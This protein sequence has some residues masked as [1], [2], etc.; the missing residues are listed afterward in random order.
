M[1]FLTLV[2]HAKSSWEEPEC[3]D[4]DRPLN[5]RGC[6]DASKMAVAAAKMG[7]QPQHIVT[8]SSKRTLETLK[9]FIDA[10]AFK[11]A[12]VTSTESIYEASTGELLDIIA[13]QP[14]HFK[15]LAMVGHNPGLTDLTEAL[16]GVNLRN[17]PTCGLVTLATTVDS[18]TEI[19][20]SDFKL[21]LLLTPKGIANSQL[22]Q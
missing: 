19:R 17:L 5:K 10:G 15:S 6:R 8:S 9:L 20:A 13:G 12:K 18:W 3:D 14:N 21:L 11:G 4:F 22:N 1:L 2:R 7:C 16:S